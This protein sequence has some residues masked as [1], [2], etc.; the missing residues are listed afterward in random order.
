M[1]VLQPK[2]YYCRLVPAATEPIFQKDEVK[3][4]RLGEAMRYNSEREGT[5][6][7]RV[8]YTY[9]S[10]FV[11]HDLT[12]DLTPL[13]GPYLDAERTANHRTP[14]L[15]LDHV[16]GGGPEQSPELYWG[17]R[18]AE[19]FKVGVTTPTGYSRD[20]PIEQA[21]IL[22]G[23]GEDM[24]DSDN[25]ILRQ[26]HVLFL[27]FHN[28]AV[29]QLCAKGLTI[30]GT[31][32]LGPGTI[33]ERAQRLVR[34]HYQWIV[35][36]DLL[37][38][39]L[40]FG[41]WSRQDWTGWKR[42]HPNGSFAIPIEFSLAAFRFGHSMV[43]N[44]YGINCR[45]TRVT[46]SDLMALGHK[47]CPIED[48]FMIEW[49]RFFDGLPRSGPVASSSFIDTSI[50]ASLHDL[51]PSIVHLS[52]RMEHS[53][54][55]ARLPVRTLLRGARARLPSGQEVADVLVRRGVI[56]PE[57]R[58]TKAQLTQNT[59]NNSGRILR[60][61]GLEENTPLFYY[62]LKEAEVIARGL[63]LGPIGSYIVATVIESALEADPNSYV[64]VVGHD[65]KLPLWRFRNGSDEQVISMIRLIRLL[66]DNQLLPECE[67]R[68]RE[69]FALDL[70]SHRNS[71]FGR[72]S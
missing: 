29:R 22:L 65:W 61:V 43:R 49:G 25:L 20:L 32:T 48:D 70:V 18:G 51:P 55:P 34:W 64:S 58:L 3:L 35:R 56:K 12:H 46:L 6:T 38:R 59:C 63:T 13:D 11:G 5:L 33:F 31:E 2:H 37:P 62:L 21:V 39:I 9:F 60:N 68:W 16:Y 47:P 27:K 44:A 66:G 40:D 7:P 28:E 71:K 52:N 42:S 50:G 67:A 41:V 17:Q 36:H 57:D 45:Q 19:L 54:E 53:M 69:F 10:Q 23:D 24:R 72:R 4:V 8:G 14:Y 30:T 26:L 1:T 15:D